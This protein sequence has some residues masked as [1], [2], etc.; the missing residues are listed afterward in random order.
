MPREGF[1]P[2]H[3][4]AYA[5]KAYVSANSTTDVYKRQKTPEARAC[6]KLD[7]NLIIERYMDCTRSN[8]T[9]LSSTI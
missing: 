7:I 3:P 1:E 5:P 6:K 8:Y 9:L 2:S 4:K